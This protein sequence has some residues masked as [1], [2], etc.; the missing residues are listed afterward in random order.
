MNLPAIE[1]MKRCDKLFDCVNAGFPLS[2]T[3]FSVN[4]YLSVSNYF[5]DIDDKLFERMVKYYSVKMDNIGRK[6]KRKK[7]KEV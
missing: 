6:Q 2:H 7:D 4:V 3:R 5:G 1:I